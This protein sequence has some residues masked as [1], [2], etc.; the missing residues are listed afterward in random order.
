MSGDVDTKPSKEH[1]RL[2]GTAYVLAVVNHYIATTPIR[3]V[4]IIGRVPL[5]DRPQASDSSCEHGWLRRVI[6]QLFG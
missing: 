1:P 2:T 3:P 4:V 5:E 6:T